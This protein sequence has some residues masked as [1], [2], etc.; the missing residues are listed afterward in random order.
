MA[1]K[2]TR[3]TAPIAGAGLFGGGLALALHQEIN[4]AIVAWACES[5]PTAFL[6]CTALT[7]VL[8]VASALLSWLAVR[9]IGGLGVEAE[10]Q[11]NFRSRHFLAVVS[12]FGA[13]LFLFA[14]ALQSAAILFLPE[15]VR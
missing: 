2:P 3:I 9:R 15:C 5:Q 6:W 8:L 4:F 12:L 7:F 11:D 14:M 10:A 1:V 13:A